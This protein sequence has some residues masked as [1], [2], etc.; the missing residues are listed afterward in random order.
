MSKNVAV[1]A[2]YL[3]GALALAV[4]V[5][6]VQLALFADV[7]VMHNSVGEISIT[8]FI[9]EAF[10][11]ITALLFLRIALKWR[12]HR[13][14]Y[15][16]IAGFFFCLLIR[17]MDFFLDNIVHGC[18][19]YFAVL[20][21]V[22]CVGFA[23]TSLKNTFAGLAHFLQH[24]SYHYMVGGLLTVLVFSRL[25]GMNALWAALMDDGYIRA[26]KNLAEE[27]AELY[28]YTLCLIAGV[29][30]TRHTSSCMGLGSA[31]HAV[32]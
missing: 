6:V 7:V 16:L 28:G 21:T 31:T 26:V 14:G 5:G 13:G 29:L 15:L 8:E 23:L 3:G 17:E 24:Y 2:R 20:C 30:Y 22:V 12:E 10:L 32:R 11:F 27:G 25:F 9:Q 18:W 19:L 4:I 1:V